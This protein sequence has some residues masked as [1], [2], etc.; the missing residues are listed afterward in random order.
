[1]PHPPSS[2]ERT[3]RA[4]TKVASPCMSLPLAATASMRR[5]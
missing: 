5:S 2:T 3:P 4:S 1:V